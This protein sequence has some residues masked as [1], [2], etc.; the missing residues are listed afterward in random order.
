M[1]ERPTATGRSADGEGAD[2]AA[3]RVDD[4]D[5]TGPGSACVNGAFQLRLFPVSRIKKA[6]AANQWR[7]DPMERLD[8]S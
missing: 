1:R 6:V 5:R 7:T 4:M 3:S 8:L 2:A